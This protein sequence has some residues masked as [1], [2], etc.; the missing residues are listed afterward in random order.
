MIN[1]Q[2]VRYNTGK[3]YTRLWLSQA[4]GSFYATDGIFS[5]NFSKNWNATFGFRRMSYPGRFDNSGMDSWN[6]RGLLRW[7]LSDRINIS[8]SDIF[9]NHKLEVN[10]GIDEKSSDYF[11]PIASNVLY[12]EMS[13]RNYR[14]DL[15]LSISTILDADTSLALSSSLFFTNNEFH[16][17]REEESFLNES[18]SI[19]YYSK[20]E[21]ITGF[22]SLF[23]LGIYKSI[24]L[25][26]G[27]EILYIN[28]PETIYNQGWN[29]LSFSVYGMGVYSFEE[30]F[31]LKAGARISNEYD[32]TLASFGTA[33]RFN[34]GDS[35][36]ISGDLS[37]SQRM[38]TLTEGTGLSTEKHILGLLIYS[39]EERSIK[40]NAGG[41]AR[42]IYEPI[43]NRIINNAEGQP[44]DL[45]SYNGETR[46]VFGFYG[47]VTQVIFYSG[48]LLS[49]FDS[50]NINYTAKLQIYTS[51]TNDRVDRSFPN[52]YFKFGVEYQ[53]IV[54]RSQAIVGIETKLIGENYGY[55]F[56]PQKRGYVVSDIYNSTAFGGIDAYISLKLGNANVRL[57]LENILSNN[58]Y[59]LSIY[60]QLDRNLRFSVSW[61]FFD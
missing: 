30:K 37:V 40:F 43:L 31:E 58:Y 25:K 1:I 38:P 49:I 10:G 42:I 59:Y 28:S 57:M 15:T 41:F 12:E 32:R 6:V 47:E 4:G 24:N 14:H 54:G 52:W 53:A 27:C 44:V 16:R 50:D 29:G 60:P 19:R 3:P 33:L 11:D 48:L 61:P 55:I 17:W 23:E 5:Q 56:F 2:E 7:N 34:I 39:L 35:S 45:N 13:E 22:R 20:T 8:L 36:F 51:R 46:R 9:T 21:I 18:D 26:T